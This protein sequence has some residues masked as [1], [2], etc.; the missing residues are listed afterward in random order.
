[1][2]KYKQKSISEVPCEVSGEMVKVENLIN[3]VQVPNFADRLETNEDLKEFILNLLD[4]V[5]QHEV[6]YK[7]G[8]LNFWRDKECKSPKDE[9]EIH[10]YLCNTLDNYCKT[11]G[12]N[13]SREVKEANG[14]VDIEFSYTN[15]DNRILKVCVEVKKA[16]HS[17]VK[18]AITTQLPAYMKSAGTQSG[19]YLVVWFKNDSFKKPTQHN[20]LNELQEAIE[21]NNCDKSNISVKII[22]CCR[23]V[24]PSKI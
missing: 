12:V 7:G 16:H 8:Y 5:L 4:S 20:S 15:R 18:T 13:L 9:I 17:S 11:K 3:D 23:D 14:N 10:P 24:S 21:K 19:I 1:M 22:N 2:K 6:S